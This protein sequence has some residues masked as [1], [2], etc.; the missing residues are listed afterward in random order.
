MH[1]I[2]SSDIN[3]VDSIPDPE[4]A[5]SYFSSTFNSIVNKHAPLRRYRVKNRSNP[6]FSN[7]LSKDL[8][9]RDMAW[10]RARET[11]SPSDCQ[12][13]K[14]LRYRCASIRK[15]K[16]NYFITSLTECEGNPAKFWKVVNSLKHSSAPSLPQ[17]IQSDS[18]SILD[19]HEMGSVFNNHFIAAGNIF[20]NSH[21]AA[22]LNEQM[23]YS[24]RSS[25][26]SCEYR[27]LFSFRNFSEN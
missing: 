7:N 11:D 9:N 3:C 10:K 2:H 14:Q 6:W 13:F 21:H 25:D 18:G 24:Y 17:L 23:N 19:K 26:S 22:A 5:F 4:L 15:A 20:E 16:S 12:H 1:D 27:A 8:H